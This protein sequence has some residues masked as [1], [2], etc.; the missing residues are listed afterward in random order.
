MKRQ[1]R[2]IV[3]QVGARQHYSVP[4]GFLYKGELRLFYTEAWFR[5][6]GQPWLRH[7]PTSVRSFGK[8]WHRHLPTRKIVSFTTRALLS[9]NL[10]TP[11]PRTTAELFDFYTRQGE[12]FA[13]HVA[14]HLSRQKLDPAVDHFFGFDS[15]S[16]ETLQMLKDRGIFTVIDQI[17]PARAEQEMVLE[18]SRKWPGWAQLPGTIPESYFQRLEQEWA[19]ADLVLVNSPWSKAG[20]IAQGVPEEKVCI[21]P[22]SYEP[23]QVYVRPRPRREGPLRVLWLGSVSLRKGIQYLVEAARGL[24]DVRFIVAGKLEIS[25]Q[26]VR[27][28]PKNVEF[29]GRITRDRTPDVY[30]NADVFVLPTLSDGFAITQVEA[31]G[32][33][34]PV[35]VTPNCGDV[36]TDGVDGF[37]VPAA[38]ANALRSA[39]GTLNDNRSRLEEMSGE[40][41][42]S[43]AR[44]RLP[45]QSDA[46]EDEIRKR[47]RAPVPA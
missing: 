12:W 36:V 30:R 31:M 19:S 43:V 46:L 41:I 8:R 34:L 47:R 21:V 3:S 11:K 27:S 5:W 25:Q 9:S 40:T 16:L 15:A 20:V 14:R 13:R 37:I 26:A 10:V 18:E 22:Q 23:E 35:I 33:G 24:P 4:R 45:S 29:I 38:D 28:C 6:G 2:W 32:Y 1:F 42:R 44:F 7:A 39:I 17:D